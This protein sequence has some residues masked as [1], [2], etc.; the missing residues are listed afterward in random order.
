AT[1]RNYVDKPVEIV[2][3]EDDEN[4]NENAYD[5]DGEQI[6]ATP[7]EIMSSKRKYD[8]DNVEKIDTTSSTLEN[9]DDDDDEQIDTTSTTNNRDLAQG[10]IVDAIND[11]IT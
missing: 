2:S 3:S 5:D 10:E 8:D 1:P 7:V 11:I 6:D 9:D 4:D